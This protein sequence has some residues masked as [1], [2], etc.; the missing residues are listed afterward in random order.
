ML[1][2]RLLKEGGRLAHLPKGVPMGGDRMAAS[3]P[4]F[5]TS[6]ANAGKMPVVF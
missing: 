2:K 1:R 4:G 3:V 6:L 5:P